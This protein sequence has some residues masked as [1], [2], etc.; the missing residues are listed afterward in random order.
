MYWLIYLLVQ[1]TLKYL[2]TYILASTPILCQFIVPAK[3]NAM[4]FEMMHNRLS[5]S[6]CVDMVYKNDVSSFFNILSL[7]STF[8]WVSLTKSHYE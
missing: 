2:I 4:I 1:S 3:L 8:Q 7:A 5:L 6:H